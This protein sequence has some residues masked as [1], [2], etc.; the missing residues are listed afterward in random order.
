M[1]VLD[2][3]SLLLGERG[4][5]RGTAHPVTSYWPARAGPKAPSRSQ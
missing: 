1:A 5:V 2:D 4:W 3:P